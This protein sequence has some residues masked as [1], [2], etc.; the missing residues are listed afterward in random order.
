LRN[1]ACAHE[2]VG[3]RTLDTLQL[4]AIPSVPHS[5]RSIESTLRLLKEPVA[6]PCR[7]R[8]LLLGLNARGGPLIAIV[9]AVML[10]SNRTQLS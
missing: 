2:E 1:T 7:Y 4:D 3:E 6:I 5:R 10:V 8:E 9:N